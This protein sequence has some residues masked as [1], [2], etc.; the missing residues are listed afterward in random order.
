MSDPVPPDVRDRLYRMPMDELR[1]SIVTGMR[2]QKMAGTPQAASYAAIHDRVTDGTTRDMSPLDVN[3]VNSAPLATALGAMPQASQPVPEAN[4][5]YYA[6]PPATPAPAPM[7]DR[8]Q[9]LR[10]EYI[11]NAVA[12]SIGLNGAD[13]LRQRAEGLATAVNGPPA[14]VAQ[15]NNAIAEFAVMARDFPRGDEQAVMH[16]AEVMTRDKLP[17]TAESMLQAHKQALSEGRY[18]QAS[19]DSMRNVIKKGW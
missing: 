16:L 8:E 11:G 12:R 13:E 7:I 17:A 15:L 9:Q 3:V 10:D 4:V 1:D 2:A 5:E 6:Q 18:R 14:D 19:L